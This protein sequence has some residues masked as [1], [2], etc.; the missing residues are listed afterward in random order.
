MTAARDD[1]NVDGSNRPLYERK[2]GM[3]VFQEFTPGSRA[4]WWAI[5]ILVVGVYAP[6][7]AYFSSYFV[8]SVL[9][10]DLTQP[11][12]T[13]LGYVVYGISGVVGT[14]CF[15]TVIV[16]ILGKPSAWLGCASIFLAVIASMLGSIALL[17]AIAIVMVG[18]YWP[19]MLLAVAAPFVLVL[20]LNAISR[21]MMRE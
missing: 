5:T 11:G 4:E 15:G 18:A 6:L 2:G 10:G 20:G 7:G 13:A 16:R 12:L 3:R 1:K 14:A 17:I 8:L 9:N 21:R 19:Y